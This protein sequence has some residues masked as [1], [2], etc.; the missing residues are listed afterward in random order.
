LKAK[1][2]P[3]GEAPMRA[4]DCYRFALSSPDIDVCMTGPANGAQVDEALA[5]LDEGPLS[6]EENERFRR[7]GAHVRANAGWRPLG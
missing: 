6:P 3:A 1:K 4:R 2:M 5:A 7:I